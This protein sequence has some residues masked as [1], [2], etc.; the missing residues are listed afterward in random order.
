MTDIRQDAIRAHEKAS[1]QGAFGYHDI[2]TLKLVAYELANSHGILEV[3]V[4]D[5]DMASLNIEEREDVIPKPALPPQGANQAHVNEYKIRYEEW[6]V[7]S[8]ALNE[9]KRTIIGL[10]DGQAKKTIEDPVQGTLMRTITQILTLLTQQ[11]HTMSNEELRAVKVKWQQGRWNQDQDLLTFLA[12]FNDSVTFLTQHD[13][14]PPQGEQV[15]T[16]LDAVA[17]VPMLATPTKA[18]FFLDA[19][20]VADQTLESLCT[21]MK[22]VYRTQFTAT[23][24]AEHH[25][26]NQATVPAPAANDTNDVIVQGIAASARATLHGMTVTPAQLDSIQA[27]VIKAIRQSLQPTQEA[28]P[29]EAT[30]RRGPRAPAQAVAR[31]DKPEKGECPFHRG[32]KHLWEH[33]R[34]NPNRVSQSK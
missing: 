34:Q 8:T 10:L 28:R 22:T 19:P 18:A 16:L 4:L 26:I 9:V 13:Y 33:C 11:Y 6:K 17:H 2:A 32:A 24:A 15:T 5:E 31:L 3:V 12:T 14:A 27:A 29:R 30:E 25:A 21:H 23:T 7:Q 1:F 20:A